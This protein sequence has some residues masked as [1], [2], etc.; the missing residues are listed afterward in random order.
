MTDNSFQTP[1]QFIAG[2]RV[3]LGH[4]GSKEKPLFSDRLAVTSL[5]YV[6]RYFSHFEDF[7]ASGAT[8]PSRES[9]SDILLRGF[10]AGW[11]QSGEGGNGEYPDAGVPWDDS[12]WKEA[13]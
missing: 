5:S 6:L 11:G 3:A 2:I 1:E 8:Q 10:K 9:E 12:L 13:L 7:K 4:Y